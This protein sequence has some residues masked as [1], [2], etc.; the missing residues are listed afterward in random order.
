MADMINNPEFTK[1]LNEYLELIEYDADQIQQ[2]RNKAIEEI[3][4]SKDALEVASGN[5]LTK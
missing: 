4:H 3:L 5:K 2:E 1:D